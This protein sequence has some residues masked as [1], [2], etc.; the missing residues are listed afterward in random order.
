VWGKGKVKY[1]IQDIFNM[2]SR[3]VHFYNW[4][5]GNVYFTSIKSL[6]DFVS[7]MRSKSTTLVFVYGDNKYKKVNT[8]DWIQYI[9]TDKYTKMRNRC[10]VDKMN[11]LVDGLSEYS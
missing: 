8:F 10:L 3:L 1:V 7:F 5:R 4:N 9:G 6:V 2:K 11:E